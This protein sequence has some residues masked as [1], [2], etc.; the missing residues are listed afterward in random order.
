MPFINGEYSIGKPVKN[1]SIQ[2]Y[3]DKHVGHGVTYWI[4]FRYGS[5]MYVMT[6]QYNLYQVNE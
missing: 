2:T 6:F 5:H 4:P 3:F 1:M